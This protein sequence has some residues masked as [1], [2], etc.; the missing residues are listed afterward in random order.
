LNTIELDDDA[1]IEGA[2]GFQFHRFVRRTDPTDGEYRLVS[3]VIEL[4]IPYRVPTEACRE[5]D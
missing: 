3:I 2:D 5:S 4:R 1:A